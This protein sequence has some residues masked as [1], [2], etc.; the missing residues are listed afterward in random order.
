MKVV[1]WEPIANAKS[2]VGLVS[3]DQMV[4]AVPEQ[5]AKVGVPPSVE[6]KHNVPAPPVA[7][8]KSFPVT[9]V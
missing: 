5:E 2:A 4:E 8:T 6:T 9:S 3:A 1:V 7:V